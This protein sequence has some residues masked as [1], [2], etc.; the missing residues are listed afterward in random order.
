MTDIIRVA[1]LARGFE[2]GVLNGQGQ[3]TFWGSGYTCK[4]VQQCIELYAFK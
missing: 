1:A 4:L 3:G 2:G